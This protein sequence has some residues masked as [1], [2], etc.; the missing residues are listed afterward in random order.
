M[1]TA[2]SPSLD[3]PSPSTHSPALGAPALLPG[4]VGTDTTL[5]HHLRGRFVASSPTGSK[6]WPQRCSIAAGV[7]CGP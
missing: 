4:Q 6:S 1:G 5:S 2:P 7:R 3:M